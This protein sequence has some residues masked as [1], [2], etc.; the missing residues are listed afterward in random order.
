MITMCLFEN[1]R[2]C[3]ADAIVETDGENG[4]QTRGH[5]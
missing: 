4:H 3:V 5:W 2:W 1:R